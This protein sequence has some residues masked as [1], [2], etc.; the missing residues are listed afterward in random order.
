MSGIKSAGRIRYPKGTDDHALRPR[1]SVAVLEAIEQD[2][3]GQAGSCGRRGSPLF[4]RCATIAALNTNGWRTAEMECGIW[5]DV[6]S[7][8]KDGPVWQ[9]VKHGAASL[10]GRQL[11]RAPNSDGATE[12]S[13]GDVMAPGSLN[14]LGPLGGY[15]LPMAAETASTDCS[16]LTDAFFPDRGLREHRF[17]AGWSRRKHRPR[18]ESPGCRCCLGSACRPMD[19][20]S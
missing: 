19:R 2:Q 4:S 20:C 7:R 13:R 8:G 10:D 3:R 1:R 6:D 12:L 11:C 16:P 17:E 5:H 9:A 14:A 18:P 15:H